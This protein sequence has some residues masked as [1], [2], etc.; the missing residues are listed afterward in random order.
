M[1]KNRFLY[2]HTELEKLKNE[3]IPSKHIALNAGIA[4]T[5]YTRCEKNRHL[6]DS[7]D[8]LW[9]LWIYYHQ[10]FPHINMQDFICSDDTE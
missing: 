5:N 10:Y 7:V 1:L 8:V 9:K 6:P 4:P 3:R 2:W